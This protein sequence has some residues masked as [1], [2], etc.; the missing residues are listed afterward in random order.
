MD[1]NADS[2]ARYDQWAT[3]ACGSYALQQ[4]ERLLQ[5]VIASWP[6][7]RQRLL[8]IGCGT[9]VFLE[10]F[11]S[12]GFDVTAVDSSPAMLS[13]AHERMHDKVDLHVARGEHLPF[14]DREFDYATV[15]T[16]LEF[17]DDPER[18][19]Q[20][21]SRVARKGLLITFLNRYSLYSFCTRS[22]SRYRRL[23][24]ATWYTWPQMRSMITRNVSVGS[25]EARSILMGPTCT[26]K[27]IPILH[28]FNTLSLSPWFGAITA[29]RVD[30]SH[31]RTGTPIMAW[32]TDPSSM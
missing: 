12:C 23:M 13:H 8:D 16:V 1:W 3:S 29:V 31:S 28:Q 24:Q 4:E 22:S 6:L 26:W 2:A 9:G 21:A 25:M 11:W 20:E 27:K 19:L 17:A 7:R 30:F 5:G 15:M 14:D 32:N 10:F 18:V